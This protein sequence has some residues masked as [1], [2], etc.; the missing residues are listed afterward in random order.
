MSVSIGLLGP[1][2]VR[3][4]TAAIRMAAGKT[5]IVLAYLIANHD[6]V[7]AIDELAGELWAGSPPSSAVANIRTYVAALR[8][9]FGSAPAP[10][11]ILARPHGYQLRLADDCRVDLNE[12]RALVERGRAAGG[13][14]RTAMRH[15]DQALGIWRG[16]ALDGLRDGPM[17]STFAAVLEEERVQVVEETVD[18]RL[19]DGRFAEAVPMLRR[20]LDD[21]PLREHAHAQLMTAL[22]HCGDVSGAL[23][24][25][26]TARDLLRDQLGIEP[27]RELTDLHLAVLDR[28]PRLD[29]DRPEPEPI[30]AA[31]PL[32]TPFLTPPPVAGFT[33]RTSEIELGV[34][35]LG[36]ARRDVLP[37]VV[38]SGLA[39]VGKTALAVALAH[40]VA[41]GYPDGQLYADLRGD[42]PDPA[43]PE[44]VI[45]RF[46]T[47]QGVPADRIPAALPARTGMLRSTLDGRRVLVV[48]D[49]A[50]GEPQV[51]ALLPGTAGCGV[52][53]T[54]RSRLPALDGARHITLTGL[55]EPDAIA[56]FSAVLDGPAD[57]ERAV[58]GG[59]ADRDRAV[60]GRIVRSCETLPLAVRIAAARATSR[61]G[62]PLDRL[63]A[64]LDDESTRLDTLRTG[65]LDIRS[66]LT[67]A[68]RALPPAARRLLKSLSLSQ[69]VTDDDTDLLDV[70]VDGGFL[71][72]NGPGRYRVH[73]LVRLVM[74][75]DRPAG[76]ASMRNSPRWR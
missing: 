1:L 53:V 41:G 30:V 33:G 15:L 6:R 37:I 66:R 75:E 21:N 13:Q 20:H 63:A 19:C 45:G 5:R 27:G 22:Y 54:G 60:I 7:I 52:L 2:D 12:F 64:L 74:H 4:G 9:S 46:L 29:R 49:N 40:R 56:L 76:H 61:P 38:V 71:T 35:V 55:P 57:R 42:G 3:R 73:G 23:A 36:P 68:C 11:S 70:L 25:F 62:R 65:D 48:L 14:P 8:R 72:E 34:R 18:A 44:E 69:G 59:P 28:S 51:R 16:S 31:D 39:G 32:F 50:A 17:L 10:V 43:T 58:T 47:A 26:A 67:G 24:A